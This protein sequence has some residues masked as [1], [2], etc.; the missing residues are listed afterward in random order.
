MTGRTVR[1]S[2]VWKERL[3]AG[4]HKWRRKVTGKDT[5]KTERTAQGKAR[6]R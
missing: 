1:G 2:C 3:E 5:E 4:P 6:N